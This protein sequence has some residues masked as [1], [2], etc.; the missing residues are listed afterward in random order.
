MRLEYSRNVRIVRIPC[1]GKTD[2]L[3]LLEAFLGGADGVMVIGCFEGDCHF[4]T[5]PVKARKRVARAKKLIEEAGLNPDR[6]D[7]FNVEASGGP[8]FKE[9]V[10]EMTERVRRLGP[11]EIK[12]GG[13]AAPEPE[14]KAEQDAE[15]SA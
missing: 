11:S 6:L 4:M 12:T 1:S 2:I 5:G 9:L 10:D 15:V 8:R 14:K 7:M 3:F 13:H